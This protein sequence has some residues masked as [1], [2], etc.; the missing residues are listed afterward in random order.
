MAGAARRRRSRFLFAGARD[1]VQL[2]GA[3]IV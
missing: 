1:S 3:M 2:V